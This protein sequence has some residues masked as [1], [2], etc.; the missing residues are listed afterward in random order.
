MLSNEDFEQFKAERNAQEGSHQEHTT[1]IKDLVDI[2]NSMM[3]ESAKR[4]EEMKQAQHENL[5]TMIEIFIPIISF[6]VLT[7][8]LSKKYKTLAPIIFDKIFRYI[9]ILSSLALIAFIL[10]GPA[11]SSSILKKRDIII[12]IPVLTLACIN[13][14]T[15][16]K[17]SKSSNEDSSHSTGTNMLSNMI[18]RKNIEDEIKTLEAEKRLKELKEELHKTTDD[19][20]TDQKTI[21]PPPGVQ[22]NTESQE[23]T[24]SQDSCTN[25]PISHLQDSTIHLS[26]EKLPQS[27]PPELMDS[28]YTKDEAATLSPIL[29]FTGLFSPKGRRSKSQAFLL[30]VFLMILFWGITFFIIPSI[31]NLP[32]NISDPVKFLSLIFM[33][34]P[35]LLIYI[36][37]TNLIKR[38]HDINRSGY[39]IILW[40]LFFVLSSITGSMSNQTHGYSLLP[41]FFFV[42]HLV[43]ALF[44]TTEASTT[45]A[46]CYGRS[47]E[48]L[49]PFL[50]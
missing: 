30:G 15:L 20:E 21:I 5:I 7:V 3:Q 24:P 27:S 28:K 34:V 4:A 12:I 39:W 40:I 42:G 25:N 37:A 22:D 44:I 32:K 31:I 6:I 14:F 48:E 49:T 36:G 17:L 13:L 9:S 38:L 46:N 33:C 18:K 43:V 41:L 1:N 35:L 8:F 11:T 26:N 2:H 16:L 23:I 19:I 50:Q 10:Y 29:S 45:G 47:I